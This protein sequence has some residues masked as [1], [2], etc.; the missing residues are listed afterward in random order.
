MSQLT[1][2]HIAVLLTAASGLCFAGQHGKLAKDLQYPGGADT[3][4]VIVR[5]KSQPT[6]RQFARL[7][8]LGGAR[9]AHFKVVPAE[10]VQLPARAGADL[11]TPPDVEFGS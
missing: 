7:Q 9:K 1:N 4:N 8:H 6:D 3:V 11:A 5:Y 2:F 10:A